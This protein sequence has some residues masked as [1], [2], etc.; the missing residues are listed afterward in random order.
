[1]LPPGEEEIE[2]AECA[3]LH[4]A[5]LAVEKAARAHLLEVFA[6]AKVLLKLDGYERG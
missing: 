3:S 1:M 2:R 5:R 4:P 6:V